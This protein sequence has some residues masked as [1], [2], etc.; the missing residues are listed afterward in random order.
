[1]GVDALPGR[2]P[3]AGRADRHLRQPLG[4]HR[5][6]ALR[7][8]AGAGQP[9]G[10]PPDRCRHRRVRD[11]AHHP[12]RRLRPRR[13]EQPRHRLPCADCTLVTRDRRAAGGGGRLPAEAHERW[14]NEIAE[15][16]LRNGRTPDELPGIEGINPNLLMHQLS[17]RGSGRLRGGRRPASDV[18]GPIARAERG[19]AVPHV[20]RH[21][22]HGLGPA[23]CGR[24]PRWQAAAR[25][26]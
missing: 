8:A 18:G 11:R 15:L 6:L 24:A 10:H 4:Q 13:D 12:P 26:W 2:P 16:R 1:M 20:R 17:Q 19:T 21:G 14:S 9:A 5:A 22:C 25:S 3:A 7:F 23:A